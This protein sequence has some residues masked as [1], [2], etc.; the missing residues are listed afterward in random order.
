MKMNKKLIV[1]FLASVIG[2]SIAGGLGG[3]FAWYQF[4]SQVRTSFIGTSVAES[5]ILQI[6]YEDDNGD[7]V[8]GR[9]RT[10]PNVKLIP[11]TFGAL[12]TNNVLGETAYGRPEAGQQLYNDYTTGWS[13]IENGKG[14]YQ[15]DIYLRALKSD[16]SAQGDASQSIPAGQKLVAQDVYLSKLTLQDAS[17]ADPDDGAYIANALRVHLGVAGGTNRL[18]SKK[19]ITSSNPLNLYDELDLDGDREPDTYAVDS[20]DEKYGQTCTYGIK[21]Q[22]QTTMGIED[23]VQERDNDGMM[24]DHEHATSKLICTTAASGDMTKITI[25]VWLEGWS[26]LKV[27]NTSTGSNV[28][29]PNMNSG[30]QVHVGMVFDAGLNIIA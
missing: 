9:D 29:N 15:Y 17:H 22:T 7:I 6:G 30:M 12:G 25:T 14:Y 5:G 21:Y 1:P 3:A 26:L 4:N 28:W 2:L 13:E 23:I 19:A 16:A 24:P 27:N 20:W 8:W 18:I 10:L 11:V